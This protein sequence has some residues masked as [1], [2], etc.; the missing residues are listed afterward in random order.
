M[1]TM[2]TAPIKVLHNNNNNFHRL[3][4]LSHLPDDKD[5]G[6]SGQQ[7]I[8]S[9]ER[10]GQKSLTLEHCAALVNVHVTFDILP[11]GASEVAL[12]FQEEL[13]PAGHCPHNT[14]EVTDDRKGGH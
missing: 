5:H 1:V 11:H 4:V 3:H 12:I 6:V 2:G 10:D 8:A 9:E 13:G 7:V 14:K